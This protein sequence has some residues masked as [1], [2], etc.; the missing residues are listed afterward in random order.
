[1][2]FISFIFGMLANQNQTFRSTQH[3]MGVKTILQIVK[4]INKMK[5]AQKFWIYYYLIAIVP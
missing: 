2:T 5:S 4:A 3:W 1:M